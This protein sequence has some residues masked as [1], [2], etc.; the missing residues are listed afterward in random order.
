MESFSLPSGSKFDVQPL[1]YEAAWNV[2]QMILKEIEKTTIDIKGINFK[3]LMA[4]DILVLK[5]PICSLLASQ[6]VLEAAKTCFK[7]CRYND[8]I[9]DN[10]TFEK[11]EAR[12]DFLFC[13]FYAL[14]ENILPFFANLVSIF[15]TR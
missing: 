9:L 10:M 3:E 8:G 12:G 5:G 11:R 13:V 6:A 7:K 15:E 2:T 14:R 1:G 4:S